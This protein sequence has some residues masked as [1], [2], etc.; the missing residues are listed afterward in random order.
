MRHGLYALLN[1]VLLANV[2]GNCLLCLERDRLK[3]IAVDLMSITVSLLWIVDSERDRLIVIVVCPAMLCFTY[4]SD[5]QSELLA[6]LKPMTITPNIM[7]SFNASFSAWMKSSSDSNQEINA[8]MVFMAKMEKVLLDSE[9]SSS[10]A[11]ETIA[12]VFYYSFDSEKTFHAV[13]ESASEN[14][15]ENH[16]VSQKDHD[17]SECDHNEPEDK[18]HLIYNLIAKFNQKIAKC[19]KRIEKANQQQTY[20]EN[21]NKTLQ[22]KYNVLKNQVNTFEEKSNEFNEQI[23]ALNEKNEDLLAQ[24]KVLQEQL[25]VKHVV[26]DTHTECQVQYAK[27]EIR[28]KGISN[29]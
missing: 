13:I 11:E 23:K 8:N 2:Y 4:H 6:C 28:K 25:K 29:I 16:I 3:A 15:D 12:E 1:V 10:S 17:E 14:I 9:K 21:E 7:L 24:M 19:Q 5:F 22:D 18:D 26:I 27:L 20:L